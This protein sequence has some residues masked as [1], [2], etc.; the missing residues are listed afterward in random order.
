MKTAADYS[1]GAMV[2]TT[3]PGV[4]VKEPMRRRMRDSAEVDLCG[5]AGWAMIG[6]LQDPAVKGTNR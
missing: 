4:N 6:G 5:V 3:A 2:V 1:T